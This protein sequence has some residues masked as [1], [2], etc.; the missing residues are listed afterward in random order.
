MLKG[1]KIAKKNI[2]GLI[3]KNQDQNRIT[4]SGGEVTVLDDIVD[5]IALSKRLGYKKIA[6]ITNGRKLRKYSFLKSLINNGVNEIAVS[7][8]STRHEIHDHITRKSGSCGETLKGL[9]N[10]F[11]FKKKI[12]DI[13]LSVRVNILVNYQNI[14]TI[15]STLNDL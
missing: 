11:R 13:S 12:P 7:L 14:N 4:L 8:Y 6:I 15:F 3:K 5:I 2:I 1:I 10:I 9:R